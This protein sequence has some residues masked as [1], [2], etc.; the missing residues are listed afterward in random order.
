[1]PS[2]HAVLNRYARVAVSIPLM[3]GTHAVPIML[4]V[5][6]LQQAD[7]SETSTSRYVTHTH[8]HTH[9]FT[10]THTHIYI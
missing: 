5:F 4:F 9:T 7:T 6:P 8:S 10:Y 2:K 1:M 3:Q